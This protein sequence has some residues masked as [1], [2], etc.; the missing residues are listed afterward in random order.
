M[1]KTKVLKSFKIDENI[2][3]FN[4]ILKNQAVKIIQNLKGNKKCEHIISIISKL[5]G[6]QSFIFTY[7]IIILWNQ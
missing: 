6:L 2:S 7:I 1:Q 4:F 3:F 5:L